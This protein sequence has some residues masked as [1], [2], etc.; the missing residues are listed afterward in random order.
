[1]NSGTEPTIIEK[2]VGNERRAKILGCAIILLWYIS[3]SIFVLF[4][5]IQWTTPHRISLLLS[6]TAYFAMDLAS[7]FLIFKLWGLISSFLQT[8]GCSE[9]LRKHIESNLF[10]FKGSLGRMVIYCTFSVII[11]VT[12]IIPTIISSSFLELGTGIFVLTIIVWFLFF[13]FLTDFVLMYGSALLI[14]KDMVKW[15]QIQEP[16][17]YHEDN[18]FGFLEYG[19]FL[20]RVFFWGFVLVS[21]YFLLPLISPDYSMSGPDTFRFILR[22]DIL[23]FWLLADGALLGVFFLSLGYYRKI[24]ESAKEKELNRLSILISETIK[25]TSEQDYW[26]INQLIELRTKVEHTKKNP[27]NMGII[28]K[29]A[30]SFTSTI[31]TSIILPN[32]LQ[33]IGLLGQ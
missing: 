21:I 31:V 1:M 28:R 16:V 11:L 30:F 18:S 29:I 24:L 12:W 26:K 8:S 4:S 19:T 7:I 14:P 10:S 23:G 33:R 32:L 17:L 20:F 25:D 27:L 6:Q 22:Y 9:E 13:A 3:A 15:N 2:L 5:P